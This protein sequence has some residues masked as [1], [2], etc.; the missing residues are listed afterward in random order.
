ME[1][2][3]VQGL[4]K[5][6]IRQITEEDFDIVCQTEQKSFPEGEP[7]SA[8]QLRDRFNAAKEL[9]LVFVID[10]EVIGHICGTRSNDDLL[11]FQSMYEHIPGGKYLCIHSVCI[12]E[13]FQRKGIASVMVN[14]YTAYIKQNF[15]DIVLINLVAHD[16][17]IS[18]YEKVGF[19][20]VG[21]S[22]VNFG[23]LPWYNIQMKLQ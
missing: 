15:P 7:A 13:K 14:H 20:C 12:H 22:S 6:I 10:G 16:Y 3:H 8:K 9:F 2:I 21:S 17:L 11:T 18:F 23:K 19:Q 5:A 4:Y 1:P